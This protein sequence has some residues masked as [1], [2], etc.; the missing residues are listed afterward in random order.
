MRKFRGRPH[1]L[2]HKERQTSTFSSP[3]IPHQ[4][5]GIVFVLLPP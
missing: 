4:L 3:A 2:N 5:S 1:S